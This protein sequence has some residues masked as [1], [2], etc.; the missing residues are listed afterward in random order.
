MKDMHDIMILLNSVIIYRFPSKCIKN[1]HKFSQILCYIYES[2]KI[3]IFL[4]CL[5]FCIFIHKAKI[6]G[7]YR[8]T[9]KCVT[10]YSHF[11]HTTAIT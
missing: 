2:K 9:A 6:R 8:S 4:Y 1:R 7:K 11:M 3:Q 10:F 5:S